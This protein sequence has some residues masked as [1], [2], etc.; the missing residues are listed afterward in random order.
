[1]LV[2]ISSKFV[3][4]DKKVHEAVGRSVAGFYSVAMCDYY[5]D[6]QSF[7]NDETQTNQIPQF[8]HHQLTNQQQREALLLCP[9]CYVPYHTCTKSVDV[10]L[11]NISPV[12]K[13]QTFASI[14]IMPESKKESAA[15]VGSAIFESSESYAKDFIDK[16]RAIHEHFD[17]DKDGYLCFQE[18]SSLQLI[19]SGA[20]MSGT[21]FGMV[22]QALG[23]RPS[24]GLG[25]DQLKLTYAAGASADEDYEKV[26]GKPGKK[27]KKK[28][29]P[30]EDDV[31]EVGDGVVDISPA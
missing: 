29:D 5:L 11:I 6:A 30:K 22:C 23:C 27:D 12:N 14:T 19:T 31:I 16:V 15:N 18:L 7:D 1:M 25:L 26:F 10:L 24:Q 28:K 4:I 3:C 17:K 8:G 2:E 13:K 21:Q 20:E 9:C